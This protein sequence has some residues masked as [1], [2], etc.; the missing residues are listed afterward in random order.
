[1]TDQDYLEQC[2]ISALAG[3]EAAS[4]NVP[5]L[6][7]QS[8]ERAWLIA[9]S[10]LNERKKYMQ[11]A[12]EMVTIEWTDETHTQVKVTPKEFHNPSKK[13]LHGEDT[14]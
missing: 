3:I 9:K 5:L 13:H 2:S 1:M 8:E 6:V 10:M 14:K 11:Q 7:S 12:F 4:N